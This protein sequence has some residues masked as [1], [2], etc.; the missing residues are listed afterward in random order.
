MRLGLYGG[1][2]DPIHIGHTHVIAELLTTKIV[3]RILVIPAGEPR[4]RDHAPTATG[5]QRRN[6][7][8]RVTRSSSQNF[9]WIYFYL[10]TNICR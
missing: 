1:T 2:F 4:L 7:I 10:A 9:D 3:D 6:G 8:N 5:A